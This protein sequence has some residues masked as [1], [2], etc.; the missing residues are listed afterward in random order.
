MPSSG[1]CRVA[2]TKCPR[3][4]AMPPVRCSQFTTITP[5]ILAGDAEEK[6]GL[7]RHLPIFVKQFLDDTPLGADRDA[8]RDLQ[9]QFDKAVDDFA[10]TGNAVEHEQRQADMFP[11]DDAAPI[12][13]RQPHVA[14]SA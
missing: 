13:L 1:L 6:A 5:S 9:Q 4:R 11:G 2:V 3:C 7:P 8:V 14:G 12:Q 10:F